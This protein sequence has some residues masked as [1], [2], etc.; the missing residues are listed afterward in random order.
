MNS[1][2]DIN[3]SPAGSQA[4]AS[5]EGVGIDRIRYTCIPRM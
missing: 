4:M 1:R 2:I 3:A 5:I